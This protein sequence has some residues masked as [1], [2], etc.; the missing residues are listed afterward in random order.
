MT[1]RFGKHLVVLEG[2]EGSGKST[3]LKPF[4][5]MTGSCSGK[6]FNILSR[7]VLD[8][9][10]NLADCNVQVFCLNFFDG[11]LGSKHR[12]LVKNRDEN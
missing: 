12:Q 9:R 4:E 10:E 6:M 2:S 7:G 11:E 5:D 1:S 3:F 8:V